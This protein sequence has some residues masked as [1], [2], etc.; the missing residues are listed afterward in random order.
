MQTQS[1]QHT[2]ANQTITAGKWLKALALSPGILFSI[3]YLAICFF[4]NFYLNREFKENISQTVQVATDNR[5]TLS[6]ETLRAGLDL[7]SITLRHIEL[8]PVAQSDR[9]KPAQKVS[10]RQLSIEERNLGNLLFSKQT[11]ER[12][13][14]QTASRILHHQQTNTLLVL[15]RSQ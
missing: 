2:A 7:H 5:Y 12:L 10:I 1:P 13:V 3:G 14:R 6:I 11:A 4:T 8:I 15:S 9:R